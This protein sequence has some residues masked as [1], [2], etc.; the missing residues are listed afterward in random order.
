MN[1]ELIYKPR[2]IVHHQGGLLMKHQELSVYS[3]QLET[4]QSS[5]RT[6][7]P[8][9]IGVSVLNDGPNLNFHHL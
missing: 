7:N 9:G 8:A 6:M 3:H 4:L 2:S 1:L 5:Q